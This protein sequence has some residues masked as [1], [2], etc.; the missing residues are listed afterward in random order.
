MS[1]NGQLQFIASLFRPEHN[2]LMHDDLLPNGVLDLPV[3]HCVALACVVYSQNQL[4]ADD[5]LTV[6]DT[7][8]RIIVAVAYSLLVTIKGVCTLRFSGL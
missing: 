6:F 2:L 3:G 1:V 7:L 5:R 8:S 4:N